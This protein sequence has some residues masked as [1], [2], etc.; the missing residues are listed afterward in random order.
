[1]REVVGAGRFGPI[2]AE[3][4]GPIVAG[5]SGLAWFW[6]ELAP[7]RTG[8][9]DTDDPATG[10]RFV[11]AHP[12]AWPIA[13]VALG[14]AALAFIPTVL[15]IRQGLLQRR[16]PMAG[17]EVGVDALTVLG[18]IGAA[19]LFAMAV[20]R[21]AGGPMLYVRSLDESWGETVYLITQFLGVQLLVPGASLLVAGWI[22]GLAWLGGRRGIVP[23]A[24][25]LFAIIPAL[26]LLG[27]LGPLGV[28]GPEGLWIV[29]VAAIPAA[30]AWLLLLGIWPRGRVV[31]RAV[32]SE[33]PQI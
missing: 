13:G 26:R 19:M 31:G 32:L 27:I 24:L 20:L 29:L 11:A 9:P 3:R 28:G 6:A 33:A 30:F 16:E 21:L 14:I 1:M 17:H 15:A 18:L 22:A 4:F 23:R 25:A 7:Q 2:V 10:L 5:I 12:D 8:F